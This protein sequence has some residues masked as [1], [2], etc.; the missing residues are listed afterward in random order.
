M[1]KTFT[2]IALVLGTAFAF[3]QEPIYTATIT[4]A[5]GYPMSDPV[6]TAT[7][8]EYADSV[9]IRNIDGTEGN[10]LVLTWDS[11]GWNGVNGAATAWVYLKD[12]TYYGATVYGT[13]SYLSGAWDENGGSIWICAYLYKTETDYVWSY[14]YWTWTASDI[15]TSVVAPVAR[16]MDNK[17]YDL[18]GRELQAAPTKGMYIQNGKKYIVR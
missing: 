14:L 8:E 6:V 10:N 7:F 9:V 1:R 16:F 2:L 5:A 4:P 12:N 18:T 3:A 15:K 11:T 17:I 13:G